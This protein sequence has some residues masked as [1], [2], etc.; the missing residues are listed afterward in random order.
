MHFYKTTLCKRTSSE[1]QEQKRGLGVV[2]AGDAGGL[3]WGV[4]VGAQNC[5][6]IQA[7]LGRQDHKRYRQM[8]EKEVSKMSLNFLV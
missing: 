6:I 3:L 2:E 5:G 7:I 8:R 1:G 4:A